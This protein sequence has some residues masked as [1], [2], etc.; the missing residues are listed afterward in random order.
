MT[1]KGKGLVTGVMARM[2]RGAKRDHGGAAGGDGSGGFALVRRRTTL[3]DIDRVEHHL[4]EILGR[5]LARS[6]IDRD[7]SNALFVDPKGL[8]ARYDVFLP[9]NVA[10]V[11]ETSASQ[12]QRIVVYELLPSGERRR[13]MY[14][15][16]VMMAG[17]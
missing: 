11:V 5:A 13:M 14:L 9:D 7:F 10:L 4:P 6:W 15:Q 17:K 8:L 2:G 16:L 1:R 3:Q 12:R